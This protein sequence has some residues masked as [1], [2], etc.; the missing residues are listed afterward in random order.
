MECLALLGRRLGAPTPAATGGP[1]QQP[2]QQQKDE[3]A[4]AALSRWAHQALQQ[5]DPEV[6]SV[7]LVRG[8]LEVYIRCHG[9]F[10]VN[11]HRRLLFLFVC[12]S[13]QRGMLQ[14][15]TAAVLGCVQT[16]HQQHV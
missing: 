5:H 14:G 16:M 4:Y 7:P 8:L 15:I 12:G 13:L 2:G 9:E 1:Q 11:R 10:W 6:K 3:P